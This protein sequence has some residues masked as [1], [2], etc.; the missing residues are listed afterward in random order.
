MNLFCLI[1]KLIS[2]VLY[3]SIR[4]NITALMHKYTFFSET[5]IGDLRCLMHMFDI[6]D[7][8]VFFKRRNILVVFWPSV[9]LSEQSVSQ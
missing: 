1:H 9:F 7:Q 2:S 8:L 4:C 3:V 5:E 6:P